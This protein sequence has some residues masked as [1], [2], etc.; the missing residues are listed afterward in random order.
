MPEYHFSKTHEWIAK[1]GDNYRMGISDF[2]QSQLGD[3]TFIELPDP[4]THFEARDSVGTIESVKA[5]SEFFAPLSLK[6]LNVNDVLEDQPELINEDPL[7][8]GYLLEIEILKPN[9][10]DELMDAVAYEEL[11]KSE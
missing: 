8:E 7:G 9:Q 11:D 6:V 10:L 2:A 1:I 5:V 4:G 3:I